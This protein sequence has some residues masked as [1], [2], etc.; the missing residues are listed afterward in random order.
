MN[1]F[2]PKTHVDITWNLHFMTFC[3]IIYGI[4]GFFP[5]PGPDG[6]YQ[7]KTHFDITATGI[8]KAISIYVVQHKGADSISEFFKDGHYSINN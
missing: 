6:D 8:F 5:R 2:F 1:I 3:L 4:M 7:T